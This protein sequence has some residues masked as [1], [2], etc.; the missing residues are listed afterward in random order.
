MKASNDDLQRSE[1]FR[2]MII[3]WLDTMF[4]GILTLVAHL[5]PNLNVLLI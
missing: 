3:T 2:K 4:H 5:I 1:I